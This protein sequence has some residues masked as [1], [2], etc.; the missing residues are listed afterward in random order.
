MI[1][2]VLGLSHVTASSG[3]VSHASGQH[4]V[5][6]V[7]FITATKHGEADQD[8]RSWQGYHQPGPE[9]RWSR[10]AGVKGGEGRGFRLCMTRF[11]LSL[12]K[13]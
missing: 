3:T 10:Q 1:V 5:R 13:H 4:L 11:E 8:R 6:G 2:V 12:D 7:E 9:L